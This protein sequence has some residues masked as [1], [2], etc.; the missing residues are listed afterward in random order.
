MMPESG[1]TTLR[2]QEIL[3]DEVR[4]S[5]VFEEFLRNFF[6]LNRTEY[7]VRAEFSEWSVSDASEDDL[8]LLPRME[9]DV[10]LRHETHT[11]IVDAKFYGKTLAESR[12]GERVRSQHLYQLITYLQNEHLREGPKNISGML[13]YPEVGR[14]LRLRYRLLGFPVVVATVDLGKKW[15]DIEADLHGLVDE[16]AEL[17]TRAIRPS[18]GPGVFAEQ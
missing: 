8:A 5:N 6:R 3:E 14:S 4:M 1:G 15:R 10:T 16:C 12:Y 7:R 17:A 18:G 9:T 2:F 13:I 11:M